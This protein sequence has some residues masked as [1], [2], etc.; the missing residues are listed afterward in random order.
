VG[1]HMKNVSVK[2]KDAVEAAGKQAEQTQDTEYTSPSEYASGQITGDAKRLTER[3]HT[4]YGKIPLGRFPM[5]Y[6]FS[7]NDSGDGKTVRLFSRAKR[8]ACRTALG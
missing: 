3:Q 7:Q 5:Y 2:S 8:A 1:K 6:R 4:D